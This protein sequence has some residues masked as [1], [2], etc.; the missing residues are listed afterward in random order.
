MRRARYYH[1]ARLAHLE[2][3]S[4]DESADFLYCEH[5]L[6]W[7]E[8][9]A[10]SIP[11]VRRLTFT[12]VLAKLWHEPY[13][14]VEIPEPLA[15][16]LLPR[17]FVVSLVMQTKAAL[18][19]RAA[20]FVVYAIENLDQSAKVS[21]ITGAPYWI[22]KRITEITLRVVFA[23]VK[24]IAFGTEGARQNYEQALG[25]AW[26]RIL[27]RVD[28]ATFEALPSAAGAP[29]QKDPWQVC[30]VGALDERKGVRELMK[31]WPAVA[32]HSPEA[33]LLILGHGPLEEEVLRFASARSDVT[34][35]IDPPRSVIWAALSRSHCLVLLSQ[36][37]P[38]WRE[39]VGLP[40]LEAL[41]K[42]CE[43][44]TTRETGIAKWLAEHG[45]RV[46]AGNCSPDDIA[47]SICD[48]LMSERPA[49]DVLRSLPIL[50]T[51]AQADAWL[52]VGDPEN[53]HDSESLQF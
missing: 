45:H 44:V 33:R 52:F 49:L 51:R 28:V 10:Q 9:L 30:F 21:S 18:G 34:V 24:R 7:D 22:T 31:S 17:L 47:E 48:A 4:V 37:T 40:I 38:K 32:E 3:L 42:G 23:R 36:R 25:R 41:S 11:G 27:G 5:R 1:V 29:E 14:L 20:R 46:L 2:R 53:V 35:D 26:P 12:G 15:I 16:S 8:A 13:E 50:D 39:Q 6:D 43:I 19:L